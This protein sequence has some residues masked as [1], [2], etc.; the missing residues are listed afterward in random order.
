MSTFLIKSTLMKSLQRSDGL[1]SSSEHNDTEFV[2]S[3]T[4]THQPYKVW[5]TVLMISN[6][7]ALKKLLSSA[8]QMWD[9]SGSNATD[10]LLYDCSVWFSYLTL[11]L[12][13]HNVDVLLMFNLLSLHDEDKIWWWFTVILSFIFSLKIEQ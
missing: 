7:R 13:L 12:L 6:W 10:H 3:V 5:V 4:L 9:E 2:S 1:T 11:I 8:A